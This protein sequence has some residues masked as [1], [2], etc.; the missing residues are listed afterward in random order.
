MSILKM[1]KNKGKKSN[2]PAN[3]YRDGIQ[4]T[5]MLSD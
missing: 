4:T 5:V 1:G 2:T 3:K